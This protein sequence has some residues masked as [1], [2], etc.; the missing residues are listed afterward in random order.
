MG[1]E[2]TSR[3]A[4]AL[5]YIA[6]TLGQ[7][8]SSLRDFGLNDTAKLLDQAKSDVEGSVRKVPE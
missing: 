6:S 8:A 3:D 1:H 4:R 7:I 2:M 5:R